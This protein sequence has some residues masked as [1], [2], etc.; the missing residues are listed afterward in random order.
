[1]GHPLANCTVQLLFL[2]LLVINLCS[3]Y[4][5]CEQI[6]YFISFFIFIY[7]KPCREQFIFF[8]T[9]DNRQ[10]T[11][12]GTRTM[13]GNGME[14]RLKVVMWTTLTNPGSH[15]ESRF[16]RKETREE[17]GVMQNKSC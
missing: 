16:G 11:D 7:K 14:S 8:S 9:P 10:P 2:L 6:N 5:T 4:Y 1:M 15:V 17:K 3:V 12:D 13:E